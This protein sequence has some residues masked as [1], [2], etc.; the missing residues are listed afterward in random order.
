[1]AT[2][3]LP[4]GPRHLKRLASDLAVPVATGVILV[5]AGTIV[6]DS[7]GWSS[8]AYWVLAVVA[9]GIAFALFARRD[10]VRLSSQR[11]TISHGMRSPTD[12]VPEALGLGIDRG[13]RPRPLG[14]LHPK[15]VV[16]L[17]G[18]SRSGKSKIA[19]ALSLAHPDWAFVS[20]G[21]F[22]R[23]EA[24]RRGLDP[25][26]RDVTDRLGLSL[27]K[28][29]GGAGFF[30]AVLEHANTPP[31]AETLI[32]DDV[33]HLAV[34]EAIEQRWDHLAFVKVNVPKSMERALE[35]PSAPQELETV[36]ERELDNA[37]EEIE[38]VRPPTHE[39]IGARDDDI[40]A[41]QR[42]AEQVSG[43]ILQA[44]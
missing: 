14:T 34:F 7:I 22:V 33:Y 26:K 4:H 44:A 21:A 30:D 18:H 40:A 37:A 20:C 6:G 31:D 25:E 38:R 41:V 42:G 10:L 15:K 11:E 17:S 9:T 3:Q 12:A 16:I 35:R 1:M 23:A 32:I 36:D 8:G 29:L 27:V 13:E 39:V 43:F 2:N 28:T 5:V 24:D 19:D